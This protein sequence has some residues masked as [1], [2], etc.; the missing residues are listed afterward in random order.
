MAGKLAEQGRT[1]TAIRP[2]YDAVV[3]ASRDIPTLA[4][5]TPAQIAKDVFQMA[6]IQGQFNADPVTTLIGIA[7]QY[8]ALDGLKAKLAGLPVPAVDSGALKAMETALAKATDPAAIEAVVSKTLAERENEKTVL[9]FSAEHKD[10]W[11]KVE[12]MIPFMIGPA[13]A[14][15]GDGASPQDILAAAYDMA[16]HADPDLRAKVAAAKAPEPDPKRTEAA[17][18]A[19]SVNVQSRGTDNPRPKSEDEE[20]GAIYD[21][22]MGE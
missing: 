19:K 22:A 3:Q 2:I 17:L 7:E 9:A 16:L 5:M 21:R 1:V 12:G 6:R 8:G 11:P 18:R 10:F 13:K 15:L 20:L 4:D 14:R